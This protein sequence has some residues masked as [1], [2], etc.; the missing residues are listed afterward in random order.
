MIPSVVS[1]AS[2]PELHRDMK[3]AAPIGHYDHVKNRILSFSKDVMAK[4]PQFPSILDF[5]KYS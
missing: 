2:T 4:I 1:P 5:D 3:P